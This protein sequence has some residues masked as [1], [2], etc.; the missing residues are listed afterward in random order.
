MNLKLLGI[1]SLYRE[2]YGDYLDKEG[3]PQF[4]EPV[5]R[6]ITMLKSRGP[7]REAVRTSI[8][9]FNIVNLSDVIDEVAQHATEDYRNDLEI[10]LTFPPYFYKLVQF[11][12]EGPRR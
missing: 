7:I 2:T 5:D 1:S 11:L 9:K 8:E 3:S 10:S 4:T 6:F 12:R